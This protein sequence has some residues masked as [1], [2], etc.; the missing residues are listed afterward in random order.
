MRLAVTCLTA[1]LLSTACASLDRSAGDPEFASKADENLHLGNEALENRDFLNAEKYFEFVKTKFPYLEAS[2][3]AELKMGDVSFEQEQ[4]PEARER[5]ESFVKLHPTH[6]KVDYAAYRAALTHFKDM[7]S[8]FFLLPPSEEKDQTEVQS[9]LRS[10]TDFLRQYPDSQYVK[11]AKLAEAEAKA[12][13]A[14]HEMYVATFYRKREHWRAVAQRL[15]GLL[16]RYP[17]TP[18]EEEALFSLHEAYLKLKEP[19]HA[20]ET[21]R[22]VLQRLPNTPAAQRAQ[23]ML[24][25]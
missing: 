5:Y 7:P 18:Y 19:D 9:A 15:E 20:Q 22:K 10:M 23:R 25:S 6:P 17:G 16:N 14:Q 3:E 2:K 11:D 13:L 1:L 21:L 24:G 12:R 8:N 4:W